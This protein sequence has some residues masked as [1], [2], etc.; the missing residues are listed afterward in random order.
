MTRKERIATLVEINAKMVEINAKM[1][2]IRRKYHSACE[3]A[4]LA[5]PFIPDPTKWDREAV[6]GMSEAASELCFK[7]QH[8]ME[9]AEQ[10]LLDIPVMDCD[11]V[12]L[13]TTKNTKGTES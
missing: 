2:E 5:H 1:A 9:A 8:E 10:L 4:E 13:P 3:A 12:L 7:A 6:F 11:G